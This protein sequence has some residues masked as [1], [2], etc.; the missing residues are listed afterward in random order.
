[1]IVLAIRKPDGRMIFNPSAEMLVS[2]GDVL[3]VMGERP[4]LQSLETVLSE[5]G[6]QL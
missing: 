3:I 4:G 5:A 1:V 2:D 6:V